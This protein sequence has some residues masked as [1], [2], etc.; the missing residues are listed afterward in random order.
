MSKRRKKTLQELTIKDNF[1]FGAVM[2]EE[3]NCKE[4][5]ELVLG[6]SIESVQVNK[7]KSIVY[8]PE[9]KGIRLDVV[10][11]DTK[12]TH[13]NVEMQALRHSALG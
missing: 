11:N 1:M 6:V 9:F 8:H 2:M 13:Y 5:L 12:K 7:E 10:A 4:L 3:E